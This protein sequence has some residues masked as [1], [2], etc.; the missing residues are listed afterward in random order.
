M[1]PLSNVLALLKLHSY[2]CGGFDIGGAISLQFPAH[3]CIKC[4][5]V[6]SGQVWL[7]VEGQQPVHLT[8][9]DCFLL[10][11]GG[12]FRLGRDL[13]LPPVDALA[14]FV[15]EQGKIRRFNGGGDYF[16]AGSRF[17]LAD[18]HA[19]MLLGVLPPML[20]LKKSSETAQLRWSIDRMMEELQS[21]QPGSALMAQYLAHM[22]LVQALR[23]HLSEGHQGG[24]G[25]LFAL[26]DRQISMAISAMHEQPG[27]PW[28]LAQLAQRVGMSRSVFAQKF[29]QT[30]GQS[31]GEYL[32]HW[33]M[34]LAGDRLLY[35]ADPVSV[36]GTA[37]G[38]Q[39]EAAFSTAFKR[40]MGRSP[41][42]YGRGSAVQTS[43]G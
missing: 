12:P 28:S 40:V 5:A 41:R 35:S 21:P 43:N 37:L 15:T 42:Q 4:Y 3:E 26:A 27:R 11:R 30:V 16:I 9:G 24:V 19:S 20:V 18:D 33:R 34:R 31:P 10:R 14:L 2:G 17:A 13:A 39:S 8:E 7:A 22:M 36:I 6:V 1:D 32:T 23:L 25:W 38:Y 29:K